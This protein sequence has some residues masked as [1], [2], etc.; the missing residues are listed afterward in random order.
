[1]H[2]DVRY[3]IVLVSLVNRAKIKT[4]LRTGYALVYTSKF[5]AVIIKQVGLAAWSKCRFSHLGVA[6][7]KYSNII[8][9]KVLVESRSKS[10]VTVFL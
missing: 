8:S 4:P 3:S 1:M 2:G 7:G 9:N 10:R 5:P 6:G